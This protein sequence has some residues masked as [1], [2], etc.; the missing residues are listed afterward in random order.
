[1]LRT[2]LYLIA[3]VFAISILRAV[4]GLIRKAVSELFEPSPTAPAKP[5]TPPSEA[6]QKDP[7]CGTFIAPSVSVQKTIGGQTY[8]F[9]STACRDKFKTA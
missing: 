3:T 1:M 5:G 8:Y 6:L 2:L 9:C 7:V 4:I